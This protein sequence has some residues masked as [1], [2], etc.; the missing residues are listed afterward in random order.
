MDTSPNPSDPME[1]MPAPAAC[2][3]PDESTQQTKTSPDLFLPSC[4]NNM[5]LDAFPNDFEELDFPD[6]A[7]GVEV[8]ISN[9]SEFDSNSFLSTPDI[10]ADFAIA[11]PT[12][13]S[14]M[15][16]LA[17]FDDAD[18]FA[19][20]PQFPE[21]D[22][23]PTPFPNANLY[24]A[25][26]DLAPAP[27]PSLPTAAYQPGACFHPAVGWYLPIQPTVHVPY[28]PAVVESVYPTYTESAGQQP[29]PVIEPPPQQSFPVLEPVPQQSV[30]TIRYDDYYA[31]HGSN[32]R[33][34]DESDPSPP[35]RRRRGKARRVVDDD[36]DEIVVAPSP[37]PVSTSNDC[38]CSQPKIARPRNSFI[39][40]RSHCSKQA[41]RHEPNHQ[42][43]SILAAEAWWRASAETKAE[44]AALAKAERAEHK[45]KYPEYKYR[46]T[47]NRK[48]CTCSVQGHQQV[49]EVAEDQ[50]DDAILDP[51]IPDRDYLS[52]QAPDGY[53]PV[54]RTSSRV[55][56]KSLATPTRRSPR[57]HRAHVSYAELGED[58]LFLEE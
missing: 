37:K 2:S 11:A 32:K 29:I 33:A 39:I 1:V 51:H 6:L 43:I 25:S 18:P 28:G 12:E 52:N 41:L 4:A 3:P 53:E 9:M 36:D 15:N 47:K 20:P 42:K 34:A 31:M 56:S 13:V 24:S 45:L 35:V 40:F 8:D 50:D 57:Q 49:A 48:K 5:D 44:Y 54:T 10:L 22:T 16:P 17:L 7:T 26:S 14:E 55:S 46:P 30:P 19:S 21:F 58:S 27:Q 23:V 38:P